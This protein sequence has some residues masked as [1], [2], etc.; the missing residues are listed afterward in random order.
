M[1]VKVAHVV[2]L[3]TR[4]LCKLCY[5]R[6]QREV[7]GCSN[8][9]LKRGYLSLRTRLGGCITTRVV[10]GSVNH[11]CAQVTVSATDWNGLYPPNCAFLVE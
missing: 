8:K 9:D 5:S 2:L 11:F 3:D 4:A 10:D 1:R 7:E 6:I